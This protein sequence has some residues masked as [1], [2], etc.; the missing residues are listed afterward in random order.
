MTSESYAWGWI[1]IIVGILLILFSLGLYF[2]YRE[3]ETNFTQ[4]DIYIVLALGLLGAAILFLGI[5]ITV[6][7]SYAVSKKT[8]K[9]TM[10][11]EAETKPKPCFV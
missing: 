7:S 10:N 11:K 3:D 2:V 6:W 9:R 1:T 4:R 8:T 5:A